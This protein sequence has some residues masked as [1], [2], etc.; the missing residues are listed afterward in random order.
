V[1]LVAEGDEVLFRVISYVAAKV[2][3]V[4]LELSTPATTLTA[5]AIA[6][7]HLFAQLVVGV[8]IKLNSLLFGE[9]GQ[10]VP[11]ETCAGRTAT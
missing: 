6:L 7:Q 2:E 8:R 1:A 11:P 9:D 4:N 3:M 10:A 5:P